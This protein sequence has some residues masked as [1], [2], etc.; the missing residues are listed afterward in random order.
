MDFGQNARDPFC[1]QLAFLSL[2]SHQEIFFF[3]ALTLAS[4]K[5]TIAS[6]NNTSFPKRIKY[7]NFINKNAS[8]SAIQFDIL[9]YYN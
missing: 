2:N 1:L 6:S 5:E 3:I 7:F 8:S 4:V 9:N